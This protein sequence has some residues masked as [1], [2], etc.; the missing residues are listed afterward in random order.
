MPIDRHVSLVSRYSVFE[1]R[2]FD[3][4]T[5]A[6]PEA[7]QT[8]RAPNTFGVLV[9][10]GLLSQSWAQAPAEYG[11]VFPVHPRPL[12]PLTRFQRPQW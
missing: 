5:A 7:V 4:R 9:A 8:M 10:S 11:Y 2:L 12:L 6:L 3:A 1:P